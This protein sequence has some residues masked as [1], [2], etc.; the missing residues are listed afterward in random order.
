MITVSGADDNGQPV[1]KKVC[2]KRV[3]SPPILMNQLALQSV[4]CTRIMHF[5]ITL[6]FDLSLSHMQQG[7]IAGDEVKYNH[8]YIMSLFQLKLNSMGPSVFTKCAIISR[9][10]VIFMLLGCL[11]VLNEC[12]FIF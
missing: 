8:G 9:A 2:R 7:I 11:L 10:V 1:N 12:S 4:Q 5:I 3:K 6:F